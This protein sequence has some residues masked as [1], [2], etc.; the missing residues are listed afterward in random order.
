MR[1]WRGECCFATVNAAELRLI[2]PKVLVKGDI[3]LQPI[4][5]PQSPIDTHRTVGALTEAKLL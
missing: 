2:A 3:C 1:R 4:A 5:N